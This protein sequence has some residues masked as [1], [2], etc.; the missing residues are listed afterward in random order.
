MISVQEKCL[1]NNL[2]YKKASEEAASCRMLLVTWDGGEVIPDGLSEDG[3]H[4][5]GR[6][7]KDD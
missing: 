5:D 1:Q 4:T 6:L 7:V 2:L 3:V